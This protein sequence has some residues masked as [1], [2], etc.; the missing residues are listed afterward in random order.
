MKPVQKAVKEASVAITSSPWGHLA[1][2]S[3]SS[4]VFTTP[5]HFP[6]RS[7]S[8]SYGHGHAFGSSIHSTTSGPVPVVPGPINTSVPGPYSSHNT[9][10]A[11][12]VGHITPTPVQPAT[13]MSAALG[14]AAQATVPSTPGHVPPPPSTVL[15][16]TSMPVDP[17]ITGRFAGNVFERAD[18]LLSSTSRRV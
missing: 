13:P 15:G 10:P 6:P 7:E 1:V 5:T 16:P 17:P 12:S 8:R 3:E 14:A 4:S 11:S 2:R 18:R 9:T